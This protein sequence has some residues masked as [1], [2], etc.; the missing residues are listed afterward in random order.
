MTDAPGATAEITLLTKLAIPGD[1]SGAL[2]S[3][4]IWIE[5]DGKLKSDNS[6]CKLA[7][8]TAVTRPMPDA[9]GLAGLIDSLGSSNALALG[10]IVGVTPG[11]IVRVVTAKALKNVPEAQRGT[12]VISRTREYLPFMAGQPGWM[13]IDFDR[14]GMPDAVQNRIDVAG[15][16]WQALLAVTPG[17]AMA[18][19][20][21]RPSTSAGL[22]HSDTGERFAG[23]GGM[24]LYVLVEDSAD[25]PRATKVLHARC[26]LHALGW[27]VT[28]VAG[29]LLPRSIAAA[30]GYSERL[31]FEGAPDVIPPLVQDSAARACQVTTGAAIDTRVVIPDLTADEKQLLGAAQKAQ[32]LALEPQAQVIRAAHDGKLADEIVK[33]TGMPLTSAMRQVAARHRGVI[34]P[35]VTLYF[36]DLGV[37]T[38]REIL[39]SP[40]KYIGETLC[41]PMD[42]LDS[43]PNKAKVLHSTR[44]PG[45]L[46]IHSFAHGGATYDLRHDLRSA[47]DAIRAAPVAQLGDV[48]CEVVDAA[49]LEPDEIRQLVALCAQ[50]APKV[51]IKSFT[52]RLEKDRR[53]RAAARQRAA[54]A[55]SRQRGGEQREIR[56]LPPKDGEV[57]PVIRDIDQV[58]AADT[59][60][61][62]PMR[63]PDGAL[64]EMR[65][66][67]P[68]NLHQ[69][70]ASGA[71]AEP[72]TTPEG[73]LP[74]APERLLVPLTAATTGLLIERFFLWEKYDKNDR[75]L[76]LGALAPPFV[77]AFMEMDS[78]QSEH[79]DHKKLISQLPVVCSIVTMPMV[80]AD[81]TPIDGIGLDRDT[82]LLYAIEPALRSCVPRGQITEADVCEAM[83]FLC[84]EWLV[85]V[86]TDTTGKLIIIAA[87]LSL[88][89]RHLLDKRPGFGITAGKRGGGKTTLAHM[90]F[91]AVLGR[92]A[93]AAAWSDMPEERR[94]AL[95]AYLLQGIAGLVWDN[96]KLGTE[97]NCPHIQEVLTSLTFSDRILQV[98]K[99]G[100]AAATTIL[101]FI[102]NNIKFVGDT[103]SR[104]AE[105]RL[106][107]KTPQPENRQVK[108]TDPLA[109]TRHHR[110][111]ILRSLYTVLL[112]G[113]RSRPDAQVPET[114]FPVWWRLVGWPV[115]LAGSLYA[116][117]LGFS[118]TQHFIDTEAE[119]SKNA[120]VAAA[121]RLLRDEFGSVTQGT[122][123]RPNDWFMSKQIR[124]ILD[125]GDRARSLPGSRRDAAEQTKIDH[126]NKFLAMI[127]ELREKRNYN[128][129]TKLIGDALKSIV[130]NPVH[131]DDTTV[132]TLF[133]GLLHGE[134]R[135]YVETYTVHPAAKSQPLSAAMNPKPHNSAPPAHPS[136]KA[137]HPEG[138]QGGQKEGVSDSSPLTEHVFQRGSS[139]AAHPAEPAAECIPAVEELLVTEAAL[140]PDSEPSIAR[141]IEEFITTE[142]PI[143]SHAMSPAGQV[144]G[145][146]VKDG[147]PKDTAKGA[148]RPPSPPLTPRPVRSRKPAIRRAKVAD[149]A[150]VARQQLPPVSEEI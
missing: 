61:H 137:D 93:T 89:E 150:A 117:G 110:A 113:C 17:L 48:L 3:K 52:Q 65:T 36:D 136:G 40:E 126:A 114:R 99:T 51:G 84:E 60:D 78:S 147:A 46:F 108:H 12:A 71:N 128:P 88:I 118:F 8:G 94:K 23:S 146:N 122:Q 98:S 77:R 92:M 37:V 116:P 109:W 69:L 43:G 15:G 28:S 67:V 11:T 70:V 9:A 79:S 86:L 123:P 47:E 125:E 74:A 127:E 24:H 130:E 73:P 101:F 119:D 19:R 124:E 5:P 96:V 66:S 141:V 30:V 72:D 53:E 7:A 103:A 56:P 135:F 64:V 38:G 55:A 32:R 63:R 34:T 4:R 106:I 26:V 83:Q 97:I 54:L 6:V 131:L 58:L 16:L 75:F 25:I 91:E 27:H 85:D 138:G 121:L 120:G 148:N 104:I 107:T 13:L 59:G 10:S 134:N 49:E 144:S 139:A 145:P 149:P 76:Y 95:L 62:P 44:N 1:P 22:S 82:G 39:A 18:K 31:V 111:N 33:R 81:G 50:L 57:T 132:G 20:V 105:I 142:P 14:K 102:G 2:L 100:I 41:D 140:P 133:T 42:G 129:I 29:Q 35:D 68:F 112:F 45:R 143:D 80:A 87:C 90:I 21:V 115:E